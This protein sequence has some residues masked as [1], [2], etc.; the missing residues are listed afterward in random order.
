MVSNGYYWNSY[1]FHGYK[2][3][4]HCI[5]M[6]SRG[7][8]K[9]KKNYFFFYLAYKNVVMLYSLLAYSGNISV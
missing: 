3:T 2:Y 9:R 8:E 6:K 1:G 7:K 4:K 5:K